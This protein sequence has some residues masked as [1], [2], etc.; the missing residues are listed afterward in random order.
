MEYMPNIKC[1]MYLAIFIS[2]SFLKQLKCM[3]HFCRETMNE[4][5]QF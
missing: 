1:V 3:S 4:N 2:A 5:N